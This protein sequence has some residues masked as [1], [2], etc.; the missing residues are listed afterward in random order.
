MLDTVQQAQD[1]VIDGNKLRTT[2]HHDTEN[3]SSLFSC[4]VFLSFVFSSLSVFFLCLSLSL[5]VSVSVWCCGRVV[6]V[7]CVCVSYC[8]VLCLV[9]R[10][11]VVCGVCPS[12]TSPCVPAPRAHVETHVRVVPHTRGRVEWTHGGEEEGFVVTLC[13]HIDKTSKNEKFL[14][15]LT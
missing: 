5:S 8:V 9:V 6:V 3:E 4:L 11:C 12:K 15:T 2:M 1:S 7:W 10:W 13:V 14:S